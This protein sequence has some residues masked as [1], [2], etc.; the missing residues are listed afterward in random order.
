MCMAFAGSS[1]HNMGESDNPG[2]SSPA[3]DDRDADA[4]NELASV[5]KD[6]PLAAYDVDVRHEGMAIQE[7]L[8]LLQHPQQHK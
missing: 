3:Q 7:Y 1:Q 4:E 8:R 6:D 2:S 5:L